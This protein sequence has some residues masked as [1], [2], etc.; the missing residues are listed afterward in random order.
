[1]TA[2]VDATFVPERPF[3][4]YRLWR[5]LPIR[6]L[7]GG[8]RYRLCSV[9]RY[10][11]PKVWT[12]GQA[13]VAVCGSFSGRH[14]APWPTH[15]CGL[16]A[17][18]DPDVAARRLE[19]GGFR[20]N[21]PV[22]GWAY[23]QVFLAGRIIEHEHGR[24]AQFA[25]PGTVTVQTPRR[26]V[27]DAVA[28]EYGIDVEWREVPLRELWNRDK[29]D[30]GHPVIDLN[31]ATFATEL[32]QYAAAFTEL[33][34]E[35]EALAELHAQEQ[36][37]SWARRNEQIARA[38]EQGRALGRW[39]AITER[40]AKLPASPPLP[41][42]VVFRALLAALCSRDIFRDELQASVPHRTSCPGR[43]C[44]CQQPT[45][46]AALSDIA[47]AVLY[48]RRHEDTYRPLA[49][50]CLLPALRRLAEAG[51]VER[52]TRKNWTS[53]PTPAW[54]YTPA[55]LE[56][57]AASAPRVIRTVAGY[58]VG[59]CATTRKTAPTIRGLSIPSFEACEDVAAATP[60]WRAARYE[61][62]AKGRRY[63][64]E[65]L[66]AWRAESKALNV[67]RLPLTPE[68]VLAT[69]RRTRAPLPASAIIDKLAPGQPSIREV[70]A[71]TA[72]L[73]KL[74]AAGCVERH[75]GIPNV[76]A[77]A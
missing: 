34:E 44:Y 32:T 64:R 71:L 46:M 35:V 43:A 66:I 25:Y 20:N 11:R 72:T 74:E 54:R 15:E 33:G 56:R 18:N 60:G 42:A 70:G 1:V 31:A 28:A 55:G 62:R 47:R 9:G 39:E 52:V 58:R 12:P 65:W 38:E 5:V 41:D 36:R 27:A 77:V 49:P 22:S 4:G 3:V 76:W 59:E 8:T 57:V 73:V 37:A 26:A 48:M 51:L 16:W 6:T 10:G 21:G 2:A 61:A 7:D 13:T 68:E 75:R 40:R 14:E 24:R 69:L 50:R 53:R 29:T 30:K 17:F 63:Y 67:N 23:G 19:D 45:T